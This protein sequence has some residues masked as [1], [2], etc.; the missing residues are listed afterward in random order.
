MREPTDAEYRAA[1][2]AVAK[3]ARKVRE[4]SGNPTVR[5]HLVNAYVDEG[6]ADFYLS[7]NY[8][9]LDVTEALL[10]A[11]ADNVTARPSLDVGGEIPV[12]YPKGS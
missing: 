6:K 11:G 5:G 4:I 10:Q 2:R 3:I 1:Q 12:T 8:G 9:Y 7:S